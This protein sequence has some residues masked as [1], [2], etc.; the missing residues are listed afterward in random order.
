MNDGLIPRR[1]AKALLKFAKEKNAEKRVYELMNALSRS[2][3][4]EPSLEA[5]VANPFIAPGQK[6][7]LLSTAAG[8]ASTD[9]VYADFLKL[10]LDNNR[11]EFVRA[12]ALAYEDDYRRENHIYKVEVTAAA[13]MAPEGETRLKSLIESHLNGGTMEYSFRVDPE[14]I[15][16]FTV[17]IG[18]EKLDA[19][20]K[21]ELE[22]IRLKLLG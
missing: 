20:I 22:Q 15:G 11:I 8:A 17:N 3:A 10:L 21:N 9:T 4:A 12:I 16:G 5:T 18:S 14:L 19:S 7:Q 6:V 13:P 1:Y 2:F